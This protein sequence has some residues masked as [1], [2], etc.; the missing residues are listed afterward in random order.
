VGVYPAACPP[1]GR[2]PARFS[3][4]LE[5][6]IPSIGDLIAIQHDMPAW[7]QHAEAVHWGAA[8]RTLTVSEPL[9][10]G[11]GAHFAALRTAAGALDGPHSVVAGASDRELVFSAAPPTV[12]YTAGARERTHVVFGAGEAWRAPARV[13]A[14]RPRGLDTV[15]IEA[16]IEDESVHTAEQGL[17]V[18]PPQHSQLPAIASAPTIAQLSLANSPA[19]NLQALLSWTPAPGAEHYEI[20][21]APGHDPLTGSIAWTRAGETRA[22]SFAL[23]ALYGSQT[24]IRVRAVGLAAGG[25]VTLWY[26]GAADFMWHS[27]DATLMWHAAD[28]TLMWRF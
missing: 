12:P 13:T 18:P 17:L 21:M 8:T 28:T 25:W 16:V 19:D 26:G 23:R 3:T 6:L 20:E 27:H 9:A 7:G 10:W 5:G 11:T 2:R 22:T 15:E 14:V 4:E 1:R 24:L